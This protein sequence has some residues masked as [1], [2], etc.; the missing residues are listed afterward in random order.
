MPKLIFQSVGVN[1]FQTGDRIKS[2]YKPLR[3]G[4]VQSYNAMTSLYTIAWDDGKHEM[5]IAFEWEIQLDT[6]P[7]VTNHVKDLTVCEV[8]K[9][10][11]VLREVLH[12][13]YYYCQSCKIETGLTSYRL[14]DKI[15]SKFKSKD[16]VR[17]T[18]TFSSVAPI[19]TMGTITDTNKE[20]SKYTYNVQI[21]ANG[22]KTTMWNVDEDEIELVM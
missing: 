7:T 11:A 6:V 10:K 5:L 16:V 4:I 17:F 3:T 19:G 18:K 20:G 1:V 15:Q 22:Y 12:K 2:V 9:S 13:P 14:T 8:C 21:M